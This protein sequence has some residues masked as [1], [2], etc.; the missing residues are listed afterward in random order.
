MQQQVAANRPQPAPSSSSPATN[1]D[2]TSDVT[3][4]PGSRPRDERSQQSAGARVPAED[5]SERPGEDEKKSPVPDSVVTKNGFVR[6]IK[7]VG[8]CIV[9][10]S[11]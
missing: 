1:N 5:S 9:V 4:E 10:I 3:G 7:V 11:F 2:V 8:K 6:F